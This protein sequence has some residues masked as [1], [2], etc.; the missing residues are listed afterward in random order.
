MV[1]SL[2]ATFIHDLRILRLL[3][4]FK[5]FVKMIDVTKFDDADK[6]SIQKKTS[7]KRSG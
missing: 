5:N 6:G 2:K 3:S 1:V 7:I 4:E